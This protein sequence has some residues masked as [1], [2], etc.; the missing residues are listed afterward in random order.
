MY[1]NELG[2]IGGEN[3]ALDGLR[4]PSNALI[5]MS[6]TEKQLKKRLAAYRRMVVKHHERH[7]RN[8]IKGT[9]VDYARKGESKFLIVTIL[10]GSQFE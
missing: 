1:S 2:L 8:D 9:S 3:F 7:K 5:D 6:G 10:H 4:L